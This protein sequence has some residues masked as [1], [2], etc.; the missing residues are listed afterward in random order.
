MRGLLQSPTA[1]DIAGGVPKS[2]LNSDPGQVA[3]GWNGTEGQPRESNDAVV[4]PPS[5]C[6]H[7]SVATNDASEKSKQKVYT[8]T[9]TR[10]VAQY[11][12]S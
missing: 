12:C 5:T 11:G 9:I 3:V 10:D 7:Q 2:R 1:G 6:H 8:P 4:G